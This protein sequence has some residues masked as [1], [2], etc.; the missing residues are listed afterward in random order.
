MLKMNG[1]RIRKERERESKVGR[2]RKREDEDGGTLFSE[3]LIR[4]SKL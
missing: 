3:P 2:E 1:E 4:T